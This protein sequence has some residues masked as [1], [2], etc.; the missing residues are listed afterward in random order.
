[1]EV[2]ASSNEVLVATAAVFPCTSTAVAN[3][4]GRQENTATRTT[5]NEAEEAKEEVEEG[6]SEDTVIA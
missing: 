1:M 2:G 6:E 5:E 3:R 4:K